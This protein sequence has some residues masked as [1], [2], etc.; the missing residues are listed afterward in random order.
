MIYTQMRHRNTIIA[1]VCYFVMGQNDSVV[2]RH[3]Q[4]GISV[5][6]ILGYCSV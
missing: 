5:A 4:V 6:L 2:E 3:W 1:L